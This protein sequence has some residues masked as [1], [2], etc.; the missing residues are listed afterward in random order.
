M[1]KYSA[2]VTAS[3]NFLEDVWIGEPP[4]IS[5]LIELLVRLLVS[6]H[7]TASIKAPYYEL[8]TPQ[9]DWK[10]SHDQVCNRFPE[11][12]LYPTTD[13][14]DDGV[15]TLMMGDAIDDIADISAELRRTVWYA[16]N[17]S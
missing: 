13:P 8:H 10:A 7:D 11:L 12:G 16:E 14:S 1:M 17:H 5:R 6:Y 2:A 3:Q 9:R 15:G 4:P